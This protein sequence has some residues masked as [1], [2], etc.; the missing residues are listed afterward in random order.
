MLLAPATTGRT[1]S[2]SADAPKVTTVNPG[3]ACGEAGSSN[4]TFDSNNHRMVVTPGGRKLVVYDPHGSGVDLAWKDPDGWKEKSIFDNAPDEEPNDRPASIALDGAGHAWV[5]WSGKPKRFGPV[6]MR[7]LTDLDAPNGPIVGPAMTVES[8][9]DPDSGN[10]AV[11]LA[12]QDGRGHIVWLQRTGSTQYSLT[13]VSFTDLGN[14]TPELLDRKILHQGS[15]NQTSATLVPTPAG[16]R[17]MARVGALKLFRYDSSGWTPGSAEISAPA[18][19]R[20]SA[21]A[22]GGDVLAAWQSSFD[23]GAVTVARFSNNGD[24]VSPSLSTADGYVEPAIAAGGS[25]A[26][27]I[28]VRASG[29]SV[30][31]RTLDGSSWGGDAT[32]MTSDDGHGDGEFTWPN[33]QREVGGTL[34]FVVGQRCTQPKLL[35]RTA[36]LSFE[37]NQDTTPLDTEITH[38]PKRFTNETTPTFHFSANRADSSFQCRIAPV[39]SD[40]TIPANEDAFDECSHLD[41]HK[42]VDPLEDGKYTFFVQALDGVDTEETPATRTFTVDTVAPRTKINNKPPRRTKAHKARFSFQADEKKSTFKCK[43]DRGRFKPC[44]SPKVYRGLKPGRHTFKVRA[45]D[46]ARNVDPTPAVWRWRVKRR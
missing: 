36:V 32:L 42:V 41:H 28:M 3:G 2:I 14:P 24:V 20:P 23:P 21:V 25:K 27:V 17:A 22:F 9:G 46:R 40:A 16:M 26:W 30:V 38:G 12:F 15:S 18:Q 45:V 6:K 37:E 34:R 8:G 39:V 33:T 1:A 11:D 19:A 35:Q 10:S 13:T 4:A 7:R 5:V 29:N 44:S 31:S 43:R